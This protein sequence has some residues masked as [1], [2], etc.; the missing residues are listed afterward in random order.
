MSQRRI[1]RD[2]AKAQQTA[3]YRNSNFDNDGLRDAENNMF[4][5]HRWFGDLL[6]WSKPINVLANSS[7]AWR[8]SRVIVKR[9][10]TDHVIPIIQLTLKSKLCSLKSQLKR[11]RHP[12]SKIICVTYNSFPCLKFSFND[13]LRCKWLSWS[14]VEVQIVYNR[15][16]WVKLARKIV[17]K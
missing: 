13:R 5:F 2:Q 3:K 12:E 14:E 15:H 16:D 17:Q 8:Y 7:S 10:L 6:A 11:T 9:V 1:F 4:D